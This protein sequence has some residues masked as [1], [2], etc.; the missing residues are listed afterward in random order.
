MRKPHPRALAAKARVWEAAG[1][2]EGSSVERVDVV[3]R[4]RI[5]LGVGIEILIRPQRPSLWL[6]VSREPRLVERRAD[7]GSAAESPELWWHGIRIGIEIMRRLKRVDKWDPRVGNERGRKLVRIVERGEL[8]G[9]GLRI[10]VS[11]SSI[12]RGERERSLT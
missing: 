6:A 10:V 7:A 3:R 12:S 4:K 9:K 8:I 2:I 1:A 5:Q 11:S